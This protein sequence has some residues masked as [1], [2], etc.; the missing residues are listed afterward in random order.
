MPTNN[1]TQAEQRGALQER[2]RILAL[3]ETERA[4]AMDGCDLSD[5]LIISAFVTRLKYK[6][7]KG[8]K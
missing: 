3:I 7:A 6:I 1:T 8:E 4:L 2:E 5:A